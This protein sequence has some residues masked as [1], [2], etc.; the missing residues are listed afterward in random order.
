MY[1]APLARGGPGSPG[2]GAGAGPGAGASEREGSS[3]C[4]LVAIDSCRC[5]RPTRRRPSSWD[6]DGHKLPPSSRHRVR[7]GAFKERDEKEPTACCSSARPP[8]AACYRP[9]RWAPRR[10]YVR[11]VEYAVACV[12]NRPSRTFPA[13]AWTGPILLL[14]F[15]R[16]CGLSLCLPALLPS[17]VVNECMCM[18]RR[19]RR[20]EH[21]FFPTTKP[22]WQP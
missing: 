3:C 14:F 9:Y 21:C 11:R 6:A 7:T 2:A 12:T 1:G 22:S 5:G 10:V 16:W 8:A 19:P 13:R 17:P 20:P 4:G 18:Q 15:F